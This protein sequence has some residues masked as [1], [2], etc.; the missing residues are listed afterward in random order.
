VNGMPINIGE[1]SLRLETRPD[2]GSTACPTEP[3]ERLMLVMSNDRLQL[4]SIATGED[5][6]ATWPSG[7]HAMTNPI[8]VVDAKGRD[9]VIQGVE[10]TKLRG[11]RTAMSIDVCGLGDTTYP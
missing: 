3:L 7:F 8:R 4:R 1:G 11:V 5:V 2:N 6:P 10:T 9:V